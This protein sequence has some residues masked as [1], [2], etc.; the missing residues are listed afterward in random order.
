MFNRTFSM[1]DHGKNAPNS[2]GNGPEKGCYTAMPIHAGDFSGVTPEFGRTQDVEKIFG[3]KKGTLYNLFEQQK[4]R[5]YNLRPTGHVKGVRLWDMA[6][7]REYIYS[8]AD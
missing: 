7:V 3:I 5:G 6:S 2:L 4:I 1:E 8:Q